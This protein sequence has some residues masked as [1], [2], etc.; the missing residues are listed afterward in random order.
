VTVWEVSWSYIPLPSFPIHQ[1]HISLLF[2]SIVVVSILAAF[3]L[4]ALKERIIH[5]VVPVIDIFLQ[6]PLVVAIRV[7][8]HSFFAVFAIAQ[9]YN[10]SF[11]ILLQNSKT[12]FIS[13][14]VFSSHHIMS[15][16]R[17]PTFYSTTNIISK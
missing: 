11:Q 5:F 17:H 16:L 13:F 1:T 9:I 7:K 3:F 10:R 8:W 15:V 14:Q 4:C 2:V 12:F 6:G